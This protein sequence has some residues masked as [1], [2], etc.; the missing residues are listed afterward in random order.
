METK[1]KYRM[2]INPRFTMKKILINKS[3]INEFYIDASGRRMIRNGQVKAIANHLR[4]GGHYSSPL[5]V[6][7]LKKLMKMVDGNHRYEAIK[8]VMDEDPTFSINSW[9]AVYTDLNENQEK[10][11]Y[12][13]WNVGVKQSATDFLK[14][15]WSTIP[16]RNRLL[17]ELPVSIYGD[18]KTLP[19]KAFVGNQITA[20]RGREHFEGGYS[21]GIYQ[22]VGDFQ[23]LTPED[24]DTLKEFAD[25]IKKV[26]GKY[27]SKIVKFYTTTAISAT[28]QIWYDNK[29]SISED[30]M[31]KCF[32]K[33]LN[34]DDDLLVSASKGGGVTAAKSFYYDIIRRLNI[35]Y[36]RTKF[37]TSEE[38]FDEK[39]KKKSEAKKE[40]EIIALVRK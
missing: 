18:K 5:V 33:A 31:L 22:V 16:M 26:L 12:R 3:T 30:T 8:M 38:V 27:E 17:K 15:H 1:I 4:S 34:K 23:Q 29:D 39:Q 25:F 28:Y 35:L 32:Q 24:I 20:K 9:V 7:K 21:G 11:V 19:I 13:E 37:K 14:A 40:K 36:K 10:E 2:T 6:N